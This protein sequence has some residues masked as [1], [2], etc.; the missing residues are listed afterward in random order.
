MMVISQVYLVNK[1]LIS[2]KTLLFI[3]IINLMGN[4]NGEE[5]TN[6]P[7]ISDMDEEVA[8]WV[9]ARQ[10]INMSDEARKDF[11]D[12]LNEKN[13]ELA[14]EESKYVATAKSILP[15]LLEIFKKTWEEDESKSD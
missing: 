1:L 3:F 14:F 2:I 11:M 4:I 7:G 13:P 12:V 6:R 8:P 9:T 5:K 10:F 15:G